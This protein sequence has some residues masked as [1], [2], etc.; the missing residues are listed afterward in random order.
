MAKGR[1]R[2]TKSKTT[3]KARRRNNKQEIDLSVIG[4]I[5]FSVLLAVLLYTN[6]GE[7]G[8]KLNEVLGGLMGIFKYVLP[9]RNIC[10]SNKNGV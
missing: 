6:S 5:V 3:Y 2:N 8:Q 1:R 4:T 7:I 9:I 10:Y